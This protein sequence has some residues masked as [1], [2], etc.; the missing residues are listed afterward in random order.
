MK[1]QLWCHCK[2]YLFAGMNRQI[3]KQACRWVGRL[4]V[5]QLGRHARIYISRPNAGSRSLKR[6]VYNKN[7]SLERFPSY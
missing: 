2:I 6:L 7:I 1:A 3:G 5:R 4:V